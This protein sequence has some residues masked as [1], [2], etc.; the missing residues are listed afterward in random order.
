[1]LVLMPGGYLCSNN[2]LAKSPDLAHMLEER[3][4]NNEYLITSFL[5]VIPY[6]KHSACMTC[7]VLLGAMI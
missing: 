5:S 7:E 2:E 3:E 6:P 4:V 1:M